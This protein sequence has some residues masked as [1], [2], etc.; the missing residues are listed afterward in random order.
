MTTPL[1]LNFISHLILK[2][3][4]FKNDLYKLI[5]VPIL[6]CDEGIGSFW[7]IKEFSGTSS[8]SYNSVRFW[9][10]LLGDCVTK[11]KFLCLR[12]SKA[13][14]TKML[15]FAAQKCSLQGQKGRTGG[16]CSKTPNF[17]V[18]LGESFIYFLLFLYLAA[19]G[20]HFCTWAFSVLV[21]HGFSS[22]SVWAQ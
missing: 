17:L 18:D 4:N 19:L 3:K 20:S 15:E 2:D 13:R 8:V 16:L 1:C 9:H 11:L 14:K 12:H 10:C 21:A 7:Y 5:V 6:K 22:C